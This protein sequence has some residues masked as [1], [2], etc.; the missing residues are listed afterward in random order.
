MRIAYVQKNFHANNAGLVKGLTSRGHE[1]LPIVQYPPSAKSPPMNTGLDPIV[2]PYAAASRRRYENDRKRLDR[3]GLPAIGQ[4]FRALREFRPDVVI[5]REVRGVSLVAVQIARALGATP[6][7]L[8]DKPLTARKRLSL[9]LLGPL[10]LPRRKIHMAYF[11]EIGELV[12]LGGLIGPSLLSTYPVES[13]PLRTQKKRATNDRVRLVAIGSL[14]NR[15][16]RFDWIIDAIATRGIAD[17]VDVTFIGLGSESSYSFNVV[18]ER[19]AALGVRPSTFLFNVPHS[20]V[21]NRLPTFDVLVHPALKGL[22]DVVIAEAMANGVPPLCSERCGT[23]ICFVDR[24][25]GRIFRSDSIEDF[26]QKL[27]ELV[28]DETLRDHLGAAAQARARQLLSPDAWAQRFEAVIES[29]PPTARR[30]S[31]RDVVR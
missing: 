27:D 12:Q 22:A 4:L 19:E 7:L 21:L 23:H 9:A 26:S 11:G 8:W 20:E 24:E 16:K 28:R 30:A 3:R 5:V 15:V 14:N 13:G 6:V 25:S 2:I 1:F 17:L 10:L 29:W 18:R 31:A